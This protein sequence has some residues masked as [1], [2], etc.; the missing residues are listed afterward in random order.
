MWFL[1]PAE[2]VAT[3]P[4]NSSTQWHLETDLQSYDLLVGRYSTI[5]Y[6]MV[7]NAGFKTP[8]FH[9]LQDTASSLQG[10][11]QLLQQ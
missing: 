6:E 10:G 3:N 1:E 4:W 2:C 5:C 11:Q 7:G 9:E 8:A